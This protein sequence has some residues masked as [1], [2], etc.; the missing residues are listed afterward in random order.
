MTDA[1]DR[2]LRRGPDPAAVGRLAR[3]T[4][5]WPPDKIAARH[6]APVLAELD[7]VPPAILAAPQQ[8]EEIELLLGD[9]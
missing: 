9:G 7:G 1:G 2:W 4:L 6:L 5:W 8:A 3:H